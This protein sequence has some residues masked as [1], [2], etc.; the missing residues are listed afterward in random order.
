MKG[1][2]LFTNVKMLFTA[3]DNTIRNESYGNGSVLVNNSL[4][5]CSEQCTALNDVE[6]VDLQS[7]SLSPGLVSFGSP[8]GLQEID[9]EPSTNDGTV[10]DPHA[11]R[12]RV[13]TAISAPF[14]VGTPSIKN[15]VIPLLRFFLLSL[16]AHSYSPVLRYL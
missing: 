10:L 7:G 5:V 12:Y 1:S 15:S 8:L 4:L 16:P 2:V 6:V 13:A 14:T 9:V 11:Y 3:A